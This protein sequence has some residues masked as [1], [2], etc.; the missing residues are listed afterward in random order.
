MIAFYG[1]GGLGNQL[2][3][4]AA[5]RRLAMYHDCPLV[6]DPYWFDHPM[7]GETPRPL[8]LMHYPVALRLGSASELRRWRWMRS[9]LARHMRPLLPLHLIREQD[10]GAQQ[11]TPLAPIN[12]YMVG[13]WQSEMYFADIRGHLLKELTP[14]APPGPEDEA[15]MNH[16][17][18]GT[19]VSVHVR[20]GDYVTVQSAAAFHGVCSLDYY[21]DAIQHVAE[22]VENPVL[23]VF[24]DD[25]DW[26]RANLLSPFPTH[27]VNH[28]RSADAFQD[29]RL[30]SRCRHHIIANSSFSWWGAWLAESQDGV[31]VAPEKWFAVDHP[32][33]SL[34]PAR[35]SRI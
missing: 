27:Y 24:S 9:R 8:E 14:T 35:W 10:V 20:R 6:L 19:A 22:R 1:Q 5:A 15:V 21:R 18:S 23:F 31:V 34:I 17:R 33:V 25:P 7:P 11:V 30:M 3:Q 4:Y 2:F 29:L 16:M 32:T 26:T 13:F 12:S 28:N